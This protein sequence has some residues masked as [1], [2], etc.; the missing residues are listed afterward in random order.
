MQTIAVSRTTVAPAV[1]AAAAVRVGLNCA[2]TTA[3]PSRV[4]TA[5]APARLSLTRMNPVPSV[6]AAGAG[7]VSATMNRVMAGPTVAAGTAV[8]IAVSVARVTATP[9]IQAR[10]SVPRL[11]AGARLQAKI[12]KAYG[13]AAS[14]IG[15]PYAM[16]RPAS[17]TAPMAA[18]AGTVAAAFKPMGKAFGAPNT[19]QNPWFDGHMDL[20][21]VQRGDVLVGPGGTFFIWQMVPLGA[22]LCVQCNATVT[23]SRPGQPATGD[24]YYGGNATADEVVLMSGWPA[25]VLQGTKG[26]RGDLSLPSDVRMPWKTILLPAWTGAQ[27]RN[28][29]II[30]TAEDRP[31]RYVVSGA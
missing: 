30:T 16:Y 18:Q 6:A 29:D 2:R 3:A 14:K 25:S 19:P 31:M 17:A 9:V 11:P 1:A 15:Q 27:I 26:E 20:S 28:G 13:I 22:T 10:A 23:V 8:A 4:A 12:S 24:D 5:S 7:R 21:V